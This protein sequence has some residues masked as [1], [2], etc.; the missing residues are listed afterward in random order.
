MAIIAKKTKSDFEPA[1]EGLH[2]A[3][4]CDVVDK[5]LVKDRFGES[6]KVQIRWELEE[7]DSRSKP[8]MAVNTYTLSLH[9]KSRLRPMLEAWRGKK[10][11]EDELDGFD[12]EKLIGANCQVQI[13]HNPKQDGSIGA[14][15]QAVV[16]VARGGTRL[17][18]SED[19]VRY[20]DRPENKHAQTATAD[21]FNQ[22]P[23]IDD[24]DVPF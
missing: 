24:S 5:G 17:R 22:A 4:C 11:S 12:L 15:V 14:F 1:P 8:F 3:V 23:Q 20:Q 16:P 18:V 2:S 10:F 7:L 21:E 13:I 9:E 6:Y 19:Y